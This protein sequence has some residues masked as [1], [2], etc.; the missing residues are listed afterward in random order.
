MASSNAPCA[1]LRRDVGMGMGRLP[2]I[3]VVELRSRFVVTVPTVGRHHPPE[4]D[5]TPRRGRGKRCG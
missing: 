4:V 5:I 3:A 2:G 1:A